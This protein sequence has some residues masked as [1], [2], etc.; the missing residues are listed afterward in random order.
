VYKRIVRDRLHYHDDIF[1]AAG[2][3]VKLLHEEASKLTGKPVQDASKGHPKTLGGN[4]NSD[5]VYHAYHIRRGDFQYAETRVSAQQLWRNTRHL[6]DPKVTKLLYIATDEKDK[7][8]FDPFRAVFEVRFLHDYTAAAHLGDGH[9]NQNHIGMVEQ[10]ICANA[11][12]FIG[13]PLSTFTG[14][15]TRMRGACK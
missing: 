13:T 15:I 14:Y 4:V 1:C 12:T 5:A 11:H 10:V 8:F 7:A 9:L 3:V 2:R 6:L